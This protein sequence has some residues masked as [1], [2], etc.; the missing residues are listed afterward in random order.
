MIAY[1]TDDKG[2]FVGFVEC[3]KSPLEKDVFLIPR[4]ATIVAPP[5]V[6]ENEQAVWDGLSW[7]ILPNLIVEELE[8][9]NN[10]NWDNI[11]AMRDSLLDDSDWTRLDDAPIS[12]SARQKWADYRQA[13]RDLPQ[14]FA[15]PDAVVWPTAP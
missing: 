7:K 10:L 6:N 15:S 9:E 5:K 12:E 4:G 11:R 14:S 1:Q 2:K 13:L 3:E 8:I